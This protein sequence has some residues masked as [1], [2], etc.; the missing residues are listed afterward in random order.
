MRGF[1]SWAILAAEHIIPGTVGAAKRSL[2]HAHACRVIGPRLLG[3]IALP[4]SI[5][6]Q[7]VGAGKTFTIQSGESCNSK[8][9]GTR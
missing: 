8:S 1:G 6:L 4:A 5:C 2:I 3:P 7:R 9:N